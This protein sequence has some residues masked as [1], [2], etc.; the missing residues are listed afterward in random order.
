M[1]ISNTADSVA[2]RIRAERIRMSAAGHLTASI[3]QS[4][5]AVAPAP[6]PEK[7]NPHGLTQAEIA[8]RAAVVRGVN[9]TA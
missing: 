2:A 8:R 7:A 3:V 1:N 5:F 9:I 6:K 4:V